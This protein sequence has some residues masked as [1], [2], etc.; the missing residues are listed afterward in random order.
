VRFIVTRKAKGFA[1]PFQLPK[2][3]KPLL[4]DHCSAVLTF[5]Q[6]DSNHRTED[7]A[8]SDLQA[9]SRVSLGGESDL[10]VHY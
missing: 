4:E 9:E 5:Q 3:A 6:V 1:S 10:L 2:D 7:Q 8:A